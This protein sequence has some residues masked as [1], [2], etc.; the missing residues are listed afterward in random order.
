MKDMYKIYVSTR[1]NKKY[2]VYLNDKYLLSFGDKRY[3]H[4]YDKF[5]FYSHLNHLNEY[6]RK[7]YRER[8]KND[9]INNPNKPGF[10]AYNYL[11]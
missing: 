2:D 9:Y 7:L 4:Y 11:W 6:R 8:H 5:L 3:Q 1:K 10:W